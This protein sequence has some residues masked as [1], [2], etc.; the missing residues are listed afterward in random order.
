MYLYKLASTWLIL[1]SYS[2]IGSVAHGESK[3]RTREK[4]KANPWSG[5]VREGRARQRVRVLC[6]SGQQHRM[7][8]LPSR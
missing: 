7:A 3:V 1:T 6:L 5:K 8:A 2:K 4:A